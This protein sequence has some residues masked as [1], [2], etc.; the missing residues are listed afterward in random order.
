MA[1]ANGKAF[2]NHYKTKMET[3]DLDGKK[4]KFKKG[5]FHETTGTPPG[6]KIPKSKWRAALAG[7]YGKTGEKQARTGLAL[8][9]KTAEEYGV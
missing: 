6:D 5:G 4:F 1:R 2:K 9:G 3:A 8:M 7:K